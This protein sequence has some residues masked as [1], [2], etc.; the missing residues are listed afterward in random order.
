V[1]TIPDE[2]RGL[3]DH[4]VIQRLTDLRGGKFERI[5]G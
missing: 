3:N 5:G 1:L 2:K 4:Q